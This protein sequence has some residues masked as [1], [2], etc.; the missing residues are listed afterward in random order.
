MDVLHISPVIVS[1]CSALLGG[2]ILGFIQFLISRND[3]KN[4]RMNE[5][6]DAIQGLK[7]DVKKLE[8]KGDERNAISARVRILRFM[9]ELMEGRRHS[10]D[11]YDQ[12]L[13]D[14]TEYERYTTTHP[15]FL[16]NQ[17]GASIE[18][19]KK[20]YAERLEKHDFL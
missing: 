18:Y 16:N 14:I 8:E 15:N 4:D 1:L 6:I 17:V 20:N 7:S 19:I 12:C 2:G 10:K 3:K 13:S 9:D 5:V 11:S